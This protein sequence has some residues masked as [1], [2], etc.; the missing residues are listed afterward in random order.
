MAGVRHQDF[1]PAVRR[2][3]LDPHALER[4]ILIDDA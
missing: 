3:R 4:Q 1:D 2:A